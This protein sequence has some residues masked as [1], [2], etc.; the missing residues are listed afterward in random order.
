MQIFQPLRLRAT[1]FHAVVG[2]SAHEHTKTEL[3]AHSSLFST[4]INLVQM[5]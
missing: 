3:L 1:G 5:F 4:F 2:K